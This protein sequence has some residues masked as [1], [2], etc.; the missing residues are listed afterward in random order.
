MNPT[1]TQQYTQTTYNSTHAHP[2]KE[3][4]WSWLDFGTLTE[5]WPQNDCPES[6]PSSS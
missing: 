2:K 5:K 3:G 6:T 1:S 4:G